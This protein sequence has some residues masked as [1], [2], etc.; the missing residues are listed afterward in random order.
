MAAEMNRRVAFE[1]LCPRCFQRRRY[2][3]LIP[4]RGKQ[5]TMTS[6]V[7]ALRGS[8]SSFWPFFHA[9]NSSLHPIIK[10]DFEFGYTD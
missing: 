2:Y 8:C 5:P 7:L 3:S 9:Q 6:L 10:R 1:R 4:F